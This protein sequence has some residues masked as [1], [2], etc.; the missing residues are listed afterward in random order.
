MVRVRYLVMADPWELRLHITILFPKQLEDKVD[1][2]AGRVQETK[3]GPMDCGSFASARRHEGV[4]WVLAQEYLARICRLLVSDRAGGSSKP[5]RAGRA[6]CPSRCGYRTASEGT[7]P[8]SA[9]RWN[10]APGVGA[11]CA[12]RTRSQA[13]HL[14]SR[15]HSLRLGSSVQL[16]APLSLPLLA[17]TKPANSVPATPGSLIASLKF[18]PADTMMSSYE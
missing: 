7:R 1:E 15:S 2:D 12:E 4:L 13:P 17:C 14:T 9:S 18:P 3:C 5:R 16:T 8:L 10:R 6:T 11:A